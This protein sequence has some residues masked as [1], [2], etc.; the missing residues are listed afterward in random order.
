MESLNLGLALN[1]ALEAEGASLE[2]TEGDLY[3]FNGSNTVWFLM[4]GMIEVFAIQRKNGVQTGP[5][6]HLCVLQSGSLIWGI[7][8]S[9]TQDGIHLLGLCASNAR[10]IQ[11]SA[12][13]LDR[14][15]AELSLFDPI[16]KALDAWITGLSQGVTKHISPRKPTRV[17]LAAGEEIA[18]KETDRIFSHKGV[19]WA[20]LMDG[21]GHYIDIK[22]IAAG[23]LIP[24]TSRGWMRAG[25][26][27][28]VRGQTTKAVLA[29]MRI[30][31]HM[32]LFHERVFHTLAYGF[33]N[34]RSAE[35]TQLTRRSTQLSHDTENTY[36]SFARLFD[37]KIRR[38]P[39]IADSTAL[40]K[41]CSTIGDA[42]GVT[43]I[44]PPFAK[45]QR[46]EEPPITIA[47]IA[48]ASQVRV[49]QVALPPHWWRS[50]S[51][52][53]VGFLKIGGE[54]VALLQKS[55]TTMLLYNPATETEQV[56]SE[57]LADTVSPLALTF[58][59]SLP[60]RATTLRDILG[61]C[62][63]PCKA[64]LIAVIIAG[65]LGG[66]LATS[67]PMAT[68]YVFDTIIPGHQTYQ[69]IQ[70]AI[71]IAAAAFAAASF[72]L[73]QNI[74]QLRIEGRISGIVQSAFMDR[75]LRLPSAF[76]AQYSSGDL[77]QRTMVIEY[78]RK[79]LTG[80]LVS[81]LVTGTFSLFSFGLL[82]Y[83]APMASIAA[84]L[85]A[86]LLA[87]VTLF[88][89]YRVMQVVIGIQDMKGRING[90]VLEILSGITKIRMAGAEE[91]AFNIWGG[92]FGN[93]RQQEI[94][95]RKR[96]N[97][98]W[99]FWGAYEVLCL[100]CIFAVIGLIGET[101]M[102]TGAFLAFVAG[103]NGLLVSL[104][105]LAKSLIV[106]F[107]VTPLYKRAV[108]ILKAEPE[109][110]VAK[111]HPGTLQGE[112]VINHAFFRYAPTL[113]LVLND[114]SLKVSA[115]EFV[116]IVGPSGSGKS[117]IMR[118]L[119]G[120]DRPESGTLYFDG[121]DL[122]GLDLRSV[123]RQIGVVLQNGR[124]IPGSIYENIKGA[125]HATIDECW[126]IAASVGLSDDIMSM[127]MKMHTL[128][129]EGSSSLSGGQIQRLL[130]ARSL[131]GKPSILL[132][133][134]ATSALDNKTQAMVIRSLDH[135]S[136]TRIV[137]A[138]RLSTIISAD[139]IYVLKNGRVAESGP[140]AQLINSGG[141]FNTLAYRQCL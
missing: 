38:S 129:T 128:L 74:A 93:L 130:M 110:S 117:T 104:F 23:S 135:L 140:F 41:C 21:N 67:I 139:R 99:V 25:S 40:F 86:L 107:S 56:V 97:Q 16:A 68:G 120:L 116:A 30:S 95:A 11:V 9:Q 36:L 8:Q 114:L 118:L 72:E 103:F 109:S 108:P 85:L 87:T 35:I 106:V 137:I 133:D 13:T 64:D 32:N 57:Q 48:Q 33:R 126:E 78:A 65:A 10:L 119:L 141:V 77:A 94:T 4:E 31:W 124:P 123:R 49:R 5:R 2:L 132:L 60:D 80:V 138:H 61:L 1:T 54:P 136:M 82:I 84:A 39:E 88:T 63:K 81:S 89:G 125:T 76:F 122:S 92:T 6:D 12:A 53:M 101:H 55:P 3:H 20:Q 79:S 50:E 90:L 7:D 22:E 52:P 127:P 66:L 71:A 105:A 91:R 100:G 19:T 134:E 45:W 115:G 62:F 29:S 113:P 83:Y 44:M 34:A 96:H 46:A 47:D 75:L 37:D 27:Q 98:F 24:L 112:I 121:R 17:S 111:L 69:M 102:S 59:A 51:G 28:T 43:M 131:V 58:Y 14:R 26:I 18:V 70:I 73:T 15:G 42:I